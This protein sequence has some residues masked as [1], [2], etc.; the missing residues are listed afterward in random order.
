[1]NLAE[2]SD[3]IDTPGREI[4]EM[5]SVRVTGDVSRVDALVNETFVNETVSCIRDTM[6]GVAYLPTLDDTE[7]RKEARDDANRALAA[8]PGATRGPL[9]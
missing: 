8:P 3:Q 4:A 9:R 6:N 5:K 7:A 2:Q 1:M